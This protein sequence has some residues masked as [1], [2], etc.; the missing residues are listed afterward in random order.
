MNLDDLLKSIREEDDDSKGGKINADK[1][2]TKSFKNPLVG[3]SFKA[4]GLPS[5]RPVV[6]KVEP[7]KLIPKDEDTSK[8][9]IEKLDELI[10]VIKKDNELEKKEQD[11]DRKKDAREKRQKREKRIEVGKIF[12]NVGSG[13][14]KSIGGLQSVFDTVIRFLAFTLLGQI[15]KFVTDFLGD[16]KNKKFLEDAQNFIRGIP[17]KL[18]EVRDKLIPVVDW[19]KE[20][21]AKDCKIC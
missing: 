18:R 19:F 21:G 16:P 5:V 4:P 13:I 3:Q 20:Q 11:Y 15:V 10:D 9:I 6:V 12:S 8:E 1:F 7:D 2:K 14:K 17:D